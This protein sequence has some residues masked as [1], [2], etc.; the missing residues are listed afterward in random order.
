MPPTNTDATQTAENKAVAAE[1]CGNRQQALAGT[2]A[3]AKHTWRKMQDREQSGT[4]PP[5][6]EQH[7]QSSLLSHA[8]TSQ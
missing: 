4:V 6:Y 7:I 3:D 8:G 5:H 1:L 2:G